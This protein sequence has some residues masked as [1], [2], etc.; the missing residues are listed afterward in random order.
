MLKN[1]TICAIATAH[2]IG[3][4]A[5]IRLSGADSIDVCDKVFLSAQKGK[6]L[7]DQK[8]NTIHFGTI[9]WDGQIIDEVLVSV[10]KA[11]HS[12][13][14]ENGI[15]ISCHGS[16]YVQQKILQIL[17]Q[18]GARMAEPGEFTLRAFMNGKIDLSQAEAVADLIASSS[19]ASRRVSLHQMRGGF[20]N[21]IKKLRKELL[22][23][24]SLIE[25]ELDFSEEDVEFADRQKLKNLIEAII[26]YID[27]LVSSFSLGNV[28]KTGIPVAIAGEPNVGKSSLL[29]RLLNE[30]KAIVSDIPGTT[31]D[32]IEDVINL[33]G[34]LFRFIDTAGLRHTTDKIESIGIERAYQKIRDASIVLFLEDASADV[35]LINQRIENVRQEFGLHT[36]LILVL[37]KIDQ[38]KS[39]PDTQRVTGADHIVGISAKFGLHIDK[40][41]AALQNVINI[42][43]IQPNDTILTNSRH[44]EAL[45]RANQ[46]LVRAMY[47]LDT[48]ISGDFLSQDIRESLLYLGEITGEITTDEVLGNIFKH[49]CIGK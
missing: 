15:E 14:G 4:I 33:N 16:M 7:C 30:E 6:K 5:V 38:I 17:L 45:S 41:L 31:R 36:K 46:A 22:H 18:S 43:N 44:F 48:G 13:T 8:P 23:F 26:S 47:G 11:P 49:F 2:G 27:R 1:D 29:N 20:S 39:E 42:G 21:E 12:Y 10:F 28:I 40:L 3:A 35:E 19:E 25:L 34:Q 37:N 24:I 32:S 9:N